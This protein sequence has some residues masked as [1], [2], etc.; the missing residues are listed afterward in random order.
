MSNDITM[1]YYLVNEDNHIGLAVW[2]SAEEKLL[3]LAERLRMKEIP[4]MVVGDKKYVRA[5]GAIV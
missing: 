4:Y 2:P 1:R 5:L 3:V